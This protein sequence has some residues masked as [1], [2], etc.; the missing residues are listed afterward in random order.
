MAISGALSSRDCLSASCGRK[1]RGGAATPVLLV[2]LLT[3]PERSVL[4]CRV[5]SGPCWSPAPPAPARRRPPRGLFLFPVGPGASWCQR[6]RRRQPSSSHCWR[7]CRKRYSLARRG[8]NRLPIASETG[9]LLPR[10]GPLQAPLAGVGGQRQRSPV[11]PESSCPFLRTPPDS[12]RPAPASLCTRDAP[13][14]RRRHG[15]APTWIRPQTA[16]RRHRPA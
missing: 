4:G 8:A 14:R 10:G 6:S 7:H 11:P 12:P 15:K 1:K 2:A 13:G 9:G 5:E 3:S 16:G